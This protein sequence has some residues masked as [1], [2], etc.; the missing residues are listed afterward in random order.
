MSL[1]NPKDYRFY[2]YTAN[3]AWVGSP[4]SWDDLSV[5]PDQ[6]TTWINLPR[7]ETMFGAYFFLS[8]DQ[9]KYHYDVFNIIYLA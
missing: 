5:S 2:D 6:G 7:T 8:A 9:G 1:K 3:P 4:F